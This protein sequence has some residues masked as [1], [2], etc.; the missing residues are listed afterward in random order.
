M[1]SE[2]GLSIPSPSSSQPTP[3]G[4]YFQAHTEDGKLS[5]DRDCPGLLA[6][7]RPDALRKD[8]A[9]RRYAS[10]IERVLSVF[11]STLQEWA[12]YI[13]FL[14]RLLKVDHTLLGL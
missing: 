4:R 8:K 2:T 5:L 3:V 11:D 9:Y 1:S 13:A 10:G 6:D 12:D 7:L 14:G